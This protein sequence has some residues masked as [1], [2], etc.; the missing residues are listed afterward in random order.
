MNQQSFRPLFVV[1]GALFSFVLL[2]PGTADAQG[3]ATGF[4]LP[5]PAGYTTEEFPLPPDFAPLFTYKGFE[6]I[7][8]HPGWGDSTSKGYWS[9]VYLWW[10]DGAP[11]I[12]TQALTTN[13][14]AYYDGLVGRNIKSRS[15]PASKVVGTVV[16][17]KPAKTAQH[18]K[19]TFSGTIAMLDYM[20]KKPMTLH[21]IIHV[22]DAGKSGK[23]AVII[24]VSPAAPGS[25]VWKELD[26]VPDG[27]TAF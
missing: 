21:A 26:Q 1:L 24:E 14:S 20:I 10:L 4:K 15:I 12:T 7:R 5:T 11:A 19:A 22:K 8:F 25:P 27:F 3:K 18:D 9:Y 13:L 6:E 23:T 16:A 2:L 17:I